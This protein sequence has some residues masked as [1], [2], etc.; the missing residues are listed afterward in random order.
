MLVGLRGYSDEDEQLES[1]YITETE[2]L[3]AI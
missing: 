1:D 3:R 2:L